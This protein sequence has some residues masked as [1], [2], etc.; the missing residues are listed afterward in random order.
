MDDYLF[1]VSAKERDERLRQF[2]EAADLLRATRK[3]TRTRRRETKRPR[4]RPRPDGLPTFDDA[5]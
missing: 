5:A 1:Y 2:A 4:S 3:G